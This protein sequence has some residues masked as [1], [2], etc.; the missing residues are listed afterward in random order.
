[1][2]LLGKADPTLV[3]GSR[4][5]AQ[6]NIPGDMSAI[7]TK[8]EGTQK[9]WMDFAQEVQTEW[10]NK[11]KEWKTDLAAGTEQ[12]LIA[13]GEL[14]L[15]TQN[16]WN[17]KISTDAVIAANNRYK[18][19]KNNRNPIEERKI[20]AELTKFATNIKLNSERFTRMSLISSEGGFITKGT[21]NEIKL[22]NLIMADFNND[23][24]ESNGKYKDGDIVYTLGDLSMTMTELEN[25]LVERSSVPGTEVQ[26]I[27]NT[28]LA[29]STNR[30]NDDQHKSDITNKI[31]NIVFKRKDRINVMNSN[32]EGIPVTFFEALTGKDAGLQ[33]Q[34]YNT[35]ENLSGFDDV[36]KDGIDDNALFKW[37]GEGEKRKKVATEVKNFDYTTAAN[38]VLLQEAILDSPYSSE[39]LS[40]FLVNNIFDN[41]YKRY[42]N[43]R[44]KTNKGS[45]GVITTP[46]TL[47]PDVDRIQ[48]IVSNQTIDLP[49]FRL[50]NLNGGWV[51]YSDDGKS[52][53]FH[54]NKGQVIDTV[55]MDN[56]EGI[57][58]ALYDLTDIDTEKRITPNITVGTPTGED[59]K[60]AEAIQL[61]QKQYEDEQI[62]LLRTPNRENTK[63]KVEQIFNTSGGNYFT[64]N[65][66]SNV[67]E[68]FTN[69]TY[70]DMGMKFKHIEKDSGEWTAEDQLKHNEE[71]W[72]RVFY[73]GKDR[74]TYKYFDTESSYFLADFQK[75]FLEVVDPKDVAAF[76]KL[77]E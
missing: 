9:K 47:N 36:N 40:E 71:A 23:G 64:A 18:G 45:G 17:N 42:E 1:M 51:K 21:G 61:Q 41:T 28:V 37:E 75:W 63:K 16:A 70:A 67:T 3:Q 35:L 34:I 57:R 13:I 69:S 52:F 72:M 6:A 55:S 14:G 38:A 20:Q 60:K 54:N 59:I 77:E 33:E 19:Y 11:E 39:I 27:F 30:P 48:K 7:Y 10:D 68:A 24:K 50:L 58:L 22:W 2:G 26:K 32:I 12:G 29:N 15:G 65:N 74:S 49:D 56:R 53:E 46:T 44:V 62:K 73:E 8:R 4:V 43:N 25:R 76:N 66:P 5:Y 31:K